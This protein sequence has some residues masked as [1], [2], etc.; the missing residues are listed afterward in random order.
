LLYCSD[1]DFVLL[2]TVHRVVGRYSAILDEAVKSSDARVRM[3]HVAAFAASAFATG[4]SHLL[5]PSNMPPALIYFPHDLSARGVKPFG[6]QNQLLL[7]GPLGTG[8][9]ACV[10]AAIAW[11]VRGKKKKKS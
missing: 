8:R 7:V 1:F 10:V 2:T 6:R 11:L 5:L 3:A 4:A 9:V